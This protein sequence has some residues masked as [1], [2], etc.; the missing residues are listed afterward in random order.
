METGILVIGNPNAS[1]GRGREKIRL[2]VEEFEKRGVGAEL[3]LTTGP[4][5]AVEAAKRA[6]EAGVGT[7]VAAGGDGCVNEVVCGIMQG[8]GKPRMGVVPTGRGNDFAWV[9]GIPTSIPAAVDLIVSKPPRMVDVGLLRCA[10]C[11]EGRHFLNG[12]GFGFEPSVNAQAATYRRLNGMTSYIAAFLHMFVHIPRPSKVEMEIDGRTVSLD[13]QQISVSNGRRM[14]SAFI[15]APD[16]VIDD[17]LIDIVYSNRPVKRWEL[18][19]MS[20]N[21]FRGTQ[22][23]KCSFMTG[24]RGVKVSI[25]SAEPGLMAH[26]DGETVSRRLTSAEVELLPGALELHCSRSCP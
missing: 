22:L 20:L 5:D 23:K 6:A 19:A 1:K 8:G 26:V 16:G 3:H 15:M 18:L 24:T 13:T 12:A 21:F 10:E 7:I 4:G 17:G 9:A 11:P 14:G 2:V 25:R